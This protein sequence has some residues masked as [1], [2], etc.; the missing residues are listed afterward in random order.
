M[1]D[2]ATYCKGRPVG[3]LIVYISKQFLVSS[4]M[5]EFVWRVGAVEEHIYI[6]E[7]RVDKGNRS[8]SKA[9]KGAHAVCMKPFAFQYFETRI[10][11]TRN[12]HVSLIS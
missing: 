1:L 12:Y 4:L 11:I 6:C 3:T 5:T 9:G 8:F 2:P 7:F 10:H